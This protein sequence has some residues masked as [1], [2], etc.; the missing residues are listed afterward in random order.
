MIAATAR[1]HGST[2]ATRNVNDF[3]G[4]GTQV[5]DPWRAP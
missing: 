4:C 3:Q 5:V 2:I 1:A